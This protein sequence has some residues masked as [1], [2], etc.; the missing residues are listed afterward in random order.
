MVNSINRNWVGGLSSGLDTQSLIDTM[1]KAESF[2]KFSLQRKRNTKT[3][4]QQMLQEVNLKLFDLQS[5][6]TD[7]TFS[8]TF[9]SKKVD[10][11]NSRIVN[12]IATT[13]AE[14]GS[15][16]VHVKQ[17]ATSTT[18]S[19]QTKLAAPLELGH[20]LSSSKTIGG[21][22]T[23]LG[24]LGV[25][26]S[27]IEIRFLSGGA[28]TH[29]I[30]TGA[31]DDTTIAGLVSSVNS[32][33]NNNAELKGK[34]NATFDEKNNRLKF[35][36]L[37]SNARFAVADAGASNIVSSMFN[38]GGEVELTKD[39]PVA[40]SSLVD[41]RS[42]LNTTL[43]DLNFT[44]G[45]FTISRSG[46]PAETFDISSLAP[47]TTVAELITNLNHQINNK[48]SLVEGGVATGR[49]DDRLAEFRFTNGKLQLVNTASGDNNNF[50]IADDTGNFTE[51]VF[52]ADSK[53]SLL[54][55][56]EKLSSETFPSAISTGVFTVDGVQININGQSD[57]LQG[58]LSR[59]TSLTDVQ[60]SYDSKNDVI[61]L[62]RKDGSNAPI[63]IGSSNDTSNFLG[64]T[65][66]IAGSQAAAAKVESSAG[67]GLTLNQAQS[68]DIGNELGVAD[69]ALRLS[70]NGVNTNIAYQASDSLTDVLDRI[71][72]VN[73][74]EDA[75]YDATTGKVSIVGADKGNSASLEVQ[76]VGTGTLAAALN[77]DVGQANGLDIGSAITSARAI[78]DVKTSV[79]LDQ[80]G[81]AT[82]ITT[83]TFSINGV[84]FNIGST[85]SMTMDSLI[86]TINSNEKV[87]AKAHY[88]PT[89]G[90]FILTSTELGNRA[91]ALG[92][93]TDTSNFLS[94]MG[95]AG[96]RQNIGQNAIYS[97]DGVYGGADQVSQ[98]NQIS[99][100]I[101]GV[102]FELF[103]ET[104]PGGEVVNIEADTELARTAID[105][106]IEVYNEATEM[107]F[108][109]LTEERNWELD[110]LTDDEMNSLGEGDL[111]AYEEAFKVGLLIG[112]TT[113]RNARSQMRQIMSNMVPGLDSAFNSL[114]EIGIT[115]GVV[116][117]SYRDTKV[118]KLQI[119]SEDKL[120]N[121]LNNNPDKIAA[122]FSQDS[123]DPNKMG[124]ARRLRDVLNE[125]TRSDGLLTARVG[126][127]GVA[128]S[129][130]QMDR[131]ISQLN[132]Q[133]STQEER[134]RSREEN[135]LRQF[136]NL[137][138]SLAN[139]QSQSQAF[140]NQLAQLIGGQ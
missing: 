62:T 127:S 136:A 74:I 116:G 85:S 48:G 81:F 20:N 38:A 61:T 132:T 42:G 133:I 121:A 123:T 15:Y 28:G 9:N 77:V 114:A 124:I 2:S 25:D 23:T 56:G 7:L 91:V 110:A 93:P 13:D 40:E 19:S 6:A 32:S 18:I 58:V 120:N 83:G 92:S 101:K 108:S 66:L 45:T 86:N 138:T 94:A 49:P 78:S 44:Q 111:M 119:T 47:D 134:L 103:N 106:F 12:A 51:T 72:S 11:S 27:N 69:G 125:F 41:I 1:I 135:L 3:L 60:A 71:K 73:G 112:D 107:I 126:R 33:I 90:K 36:L 128:T 55:K 117:S 46:G 67:I 97:I 39:V 57:D 130:S 113:L 14:L 43:T 53:A 35:N 105:D 79:P 70:I 16:T 17:L 129:N 5:K 102:T 64:V 59:I 26:A 24:S 99:D 115:T 118:G 37:D 96:A 82:P 29:N 63:G 104:A 30:N 65:G 54:D 80:A 137:E 34:I 10:T 76:D 68:S 100:V 98:S 22:S 52:G 131:Q 8:R 89:N 139:Y 50:V 84:K 31:N 21:S 122:L 140:S 4:Q 95:L 87:G 88:D 75:W 109:R